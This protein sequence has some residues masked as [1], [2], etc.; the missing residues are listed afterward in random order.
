MH[1]QEIS[2]AGNQDIRAADLCERNKHLISRIA[3]L[4]QRYSSR[5]DIDPFRVWKIKGCDGFDLRLDQA[6]LRIMQNAKKLI[7]DRAAYQRRGCT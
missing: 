5:I 3:A 7:R 1:G 6:K 4:R 2:I